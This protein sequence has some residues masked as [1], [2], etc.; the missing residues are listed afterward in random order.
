MSQGGSTASRPPSKPPTPTE[1]LSPAPS[2][3]REGDKLEQLAVAAQPSAAG[4]VAQVAAFDAAQDNPEDAAPGGGEAA[5][6]GAGGALHGEEAA[7]GKGAERQEPEAEEG[8]KHEEPVRGVVRS[9][10]PPR[11][12]HEEPVRGVVRSPSPQFEV[13]S[14][15]TK[16]ALLRLLRRPW[17][18]GFESPTLFRQ[19]APRGMGNAK[20]MC[21]ANCVM[22]VGFG[23]TPSLV[24]VVAV[25]RRCAMVTA[26]FRWVR[27]RP[28]LGLR[29]RRANDCCADWVMRVVWEIT[30]PGVGVSS[31]QILRF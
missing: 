20:T 31:N 26:L 16:A 21:Y 25:C 19:P 5:A 22:Q 3:T 6:E 7:Q 23:E 13:Q 1:V 2:V 4:K 27:E 18:G 10:S 8:R 9:P 28:H 12:K 15:E 14:P 29:R 30:H 17:E 11:R 24:W